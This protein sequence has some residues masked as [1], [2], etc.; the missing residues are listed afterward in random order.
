MISWSYPTRILF[1]AGT[2]KALPEEAA[3]LGMT[4]PLVV[5]DPGLKDLPFIAELR[6]LLKDAGLESGLFSEI[7][8]NPLVENVEAGVAAYRAGGHDGVICVG[9]GSAMDCGKTVAFMIAQS[10][11]VWHFEDI[12]DNWKDA[13]VEGIAPIIALPTTAGTGSEVGRAGVIGDA[14]AG[15]KKIIFHPKMLPAVVI[16]D[17]ELTVGLPA[18]LTAATGFDA[19]AHCLEAYCAP[20]FHPMSEGIAVEG[21]RL[22]KDYLP[23]AVADGGD[24]EAR[25]KMLIAASMG[26]VAFQKGLG[27]IHSLSHAV[28]ALFDTHH[29]RTNAVMMPY[30]LAFNRAQVEEKVAR[31]AAYLDLPPS[32]EGFFDWMMATRS[33]LGIEHSLAELIGERDRQEA[34][35]IELSITDPTAGSNPRKLDGEGA[36]RLYEAA[37]AGSLAGLSA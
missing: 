2:R 23:R 6:G 19:L 8:P 9:G 26:A 1:G 21:M 20:S 18:G 34:R 12:G 29:G 22:I 16:E 3:G 24:L 11:S 37:L 25:G 35:V 15:F 14:K 33:A 4:R 13:T 17:A 10:L 28:G 32:Y 30:V 27:A 31:L 7:K 5:T 36:A